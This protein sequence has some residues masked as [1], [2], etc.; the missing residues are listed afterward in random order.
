MNI[1][2]LWFDDSSKPLSEKVRQA[3]QYYAAKYG[4]TPTHCLVNP[5]TT[6]TTEEVDNV[7]VVAATTVMP[8]HFWVGFDEQRANGSKK[9]KAKAAARQK[10]A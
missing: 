5:E 8:N 1:G 2:M 9:T 4:R 3:V 7:Q 10:A 6:S